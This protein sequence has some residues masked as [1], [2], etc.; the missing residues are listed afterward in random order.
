MV[1]RLRKDKEIHTIPE[2]KKG[3]ENEKDGRIAGVEVKTLPGG[4]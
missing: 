1:I 4:A 3:I 2:K